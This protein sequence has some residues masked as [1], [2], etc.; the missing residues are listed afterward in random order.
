MGVFDDSS[1]D[2]SARQLNNLGSS[3]RKLMAIDT[4]TII[5][6]EAFLESVVACSKP[7]EQVSVKEA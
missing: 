6:V 2:R 4:E 5:D 7:K 1:Y 3:E